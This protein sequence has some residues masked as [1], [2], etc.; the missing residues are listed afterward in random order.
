MYALIPIHDS[1]KSFGHK[2]TVRQEG[3]RLILRSYQT[4]VAYIENGTLKVYGT[5][6]ATTT[7][8]IKEFARQNGFKA[9]TK[10]Q[11]EQY[12]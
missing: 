7:R 8:H 11:V 12:I 3:D 2:A 9:D 1:A 4:D 10:K 6:S 5:Y